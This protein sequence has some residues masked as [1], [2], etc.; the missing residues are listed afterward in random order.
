[1]PIVSTNK[2]GR[3]GEIAAHYSVVLN[4]GG[5]PRRAPINVTDFFSPFVPTVLGDATS[6]SEEVDQTEWWT[7]NKVY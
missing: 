2:M 3:K 7:A 6:K 5:H 1:M 4:G